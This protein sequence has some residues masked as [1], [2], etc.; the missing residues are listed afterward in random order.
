MRPDE[1]VRIVPATVNDTAV[2][3]R[4]IKGLADY[5][6]LSDRVTATENALREQLF[7]AKPAAEVCLAF[8]GE[9]PVGF[10][11]FH[12]TFS[13]FACRPGIYLEDIFVEPQ[14]RSRGIGHR[15]LAHVAGIGAARGCQ[16]M[17]WA[18]LPWN[19][20]A[21]RFY[22]RLGA[23]KVTEWDGFRIAGE[24]FGTLARERV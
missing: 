5:E 14:W 7:G 1:R 12:G 24:A 17:T 21:I 18:V 3:L 9:E 11:V 8:V 13:T 23:E 6:R 4:M 2:I 22:R 20:P 19:E 16:S 10:A 15:I